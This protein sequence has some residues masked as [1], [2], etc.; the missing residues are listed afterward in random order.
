M[1]K[2]K[3]SAGI[4]VLILLILITASLAY[5]YNSKM[6]E[7]N[8]PTVDVAERINWNLKTQIDIKINDESG[9]K[10]VRA[11]LSDGKNSIVLVQKEFAPAPKEFTLGLEFPR[12]GF[13]SNKNSFELDIEVV[14]SSKWNFFAGNRVTKKSVIHVDTKKPELY[15][16]NNSYKITKGGIATVIFKAQ[17]ENLQELYIETNFG[18]RFYPTPFYKDGYYISLLAWPSD[19]ESF[20]ATIIAKDVAGNISKNRIALYLKDK[21]YRVSTLKLK[22]KFINGKITDLAEEYLGKV[23]TM[24]KLEKFKF[25]N[26][27]LRIENENNIEKATTPTQK[28]LLTDFKIENFYPLKNGAAV[29][30]FGDHRFYKYNDTVVSELYH[31]GLDFAST[32]RADIVASND[33]KVV[34]AKYNGIYGENLIL[35]HGLGLYTLYGHSSSI[36]VAH[37]QSVKKGQIIAKTGST[38]LAL[39][40]H[41]H[42][43][44][45]VQGI[46]VRPEEWM[47]S[48]W[49]KDNIFDIIST[50]KK[51]IDR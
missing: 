48:H 35:S 36:L 39:G 9:I 8:V 18:K 2:K 45:V 26:E 13:I 32:A 43:G 38:G 23:D 51:I 25:V 7:R 31:R 34:F 27:K 22:D 11:T 16:V 29:A 41:L 49:L 37:G 3:S 40:D 24:D 33:G 21:Q 1:R 19:E 30:S 14:D 6:F 17:D 20:E 28:E 42:F 5:L 15:T 44:V 47:D 12:I 46:E 4:I 50:A 10:F